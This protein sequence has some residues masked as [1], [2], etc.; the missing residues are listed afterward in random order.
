MDLKLNNSRLGVGIKR[1]IVFSF[2]VAA[3]VAAA[4]M[5][6]EGG[7]MAAGA[8]FALPLGALLVLSIFLKPAVGMVLVMLLGIYIIGPTRYISGVPLGLSIDVM[9]LLTFLATIFKVQQE[10]K[11]W[12]NNSLF[13]LLVIWVVYI[14]FQVMNPE[15][16]SYAAWFYASRSLALYWV[17]VVALTFLMFREEKHFNTFI[18]VW[19][20]GGIISGLYGAKQ[21]HLGLDSAE[22][23]WL[24]AGADETHLLFGKLRVFSFFSDA[25]QFGAF[26]AYT[27]VVAAILALKTDKFW[28]RILFWATAGIC[29]YGMLI[30]GTRGA[31]FVLMIGFL[32][33]VLMTKK[34]KILTVG[35]ILLGA[36][37]CMLKF[38]YIGQGNYNIQRMRSSL[39]PDDPSFQVRLENQRK[40]K[41]YMESRPFGGGVGTAGYWGLRFSPGTLLA[42]T[43]TDSFYVRVWVET[44]V[45][46]LVL[47]LGILI[48]VF[49][50]T[51]IKAWNIR[52]PIIRQKMMAIYAGA[53]GVA[54]ASYGNQV[55]GQIPTLVFFFMSLSY[56]YIMPD[57]EKKK[58]K[59]GKSDKL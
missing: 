43:P 2:M 57:W 9:L 1:L 49:I 51:F 55:I 6:T 30:S 56:L 31:N 38:T 25:G 15:A 50:L 26:Q 24:E 59:I 41:A 18:T 34:F 40:L 54:V 32:V 14:I 33:Y 58:Q 52:D 3:T 35:L 13:I 8:L 53:L 5:V 29:F 11:K 47:L 48:F 12:L 20:W 16:V 39:D 27:M 4:Y 22:L 17:L 19:M 42:E 44:G 37:F 28:R 7:I 45:V 36:F 46:G 21:L 10:D 23:A